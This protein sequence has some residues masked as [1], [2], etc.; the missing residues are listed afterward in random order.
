MIHK[1]ILRQ[2]GGDLKHSVKSRTKEQSSTEEI[3]NI[4]EE[5]TTRT[6]M[7]SSVVN[8]KTRSWRD[9][10]EI[11]LKVSSNN[12]EYKSEYEIRECHICQSTT[13]LANASLRKGKINEFYIEKEPLVEKGD[14]IEDNSDDKSSIF[15]ESSKDIE[16]INVTFEIM[17]S[18]S[19]LPQLSNG[20]LHL[21]K[22][23]DA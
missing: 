8:L 3:I 23:Q 11:N 16:N 20:K 17:E 15:P 13:H 7:G 9:C 2:C 10:V 22:V 19:Q 4:S 1:R 14:V 18:Y 6:R 21:S 5:V 12:I